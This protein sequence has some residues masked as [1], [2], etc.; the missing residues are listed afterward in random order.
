MITAKKFF[1]LTVM[2]LL[3]TSSSG[4][5][6]NVTVSK[7]DERV[8]GNSTD[9]YAVELSGTLEEVTTAFTKYLKTFSKT[10]AVSNVTQVSEAQFSATKYMSPF[11]ATTRN[12]SDKAL[13]WIGLNPSEWPSEDEAKKGMDELEKV[14]YNFGVKFYRDKIQ[15]D[16]DEALLAQQTTEKQQQKLLNDNKTLNT[17]LEN[18]QKEKIRLE[19]AL[20]DNKVEN[21]NLILGLERNKKAQDSVAVALEQIRKMVE[22]HKERQ[23]K[24]N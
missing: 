11:Y 18:N 13:A 6:Q 2:A 23:K 1:T 22:F 14:M 8:K 20:V 4:L 15:A 16:V 17:K 3:L 19:K 5:A 7:Q 12:A 24:V 10:K 21:E 9:G